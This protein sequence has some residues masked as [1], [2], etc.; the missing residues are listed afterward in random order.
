[1]KPWIFYLLSP[2]SWAVPPGPAHVPYGSPTRLSPP[3]GSCRRC[4]RLRPWPSCASPSPSGRWWKQPARIP[5]LRQPEPRRD[6]GA[7]SC[8]RARPDPCV[9]PEPPCCCFSAAFQSETIRSSTASVCVCQ[10]AHEELADPT[11]GAAGCRC[12]ALNVLLPTFPTVTSCCSRAA[13]CCRCELLIGWLDHGDP[14][15]IP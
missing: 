12:C 8:R 14:Q 15:F 7:R 1:M 6:R 9:S 11:G 3:R 13:K 4:R 10:C 2:Q 5:T